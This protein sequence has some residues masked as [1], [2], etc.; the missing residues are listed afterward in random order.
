MATRITARMLINTRDFV[1]SRYGAARFDEM[2]AALG[3]RCRVLYQ[4]KLTASIWVDFEVI[5]DLMQ[6]VERLFGDGS[7][8]L[9]HE[10]G[11]YNSEADLRVTQKLIMRILT[12]KMVLKLAS[13]L[14]TGRVKDGGRMVIINKGP[15]AV[16]CRIE[17]PPSVSDRWWRYLAG[18][19]QRTI[20][21]AGGRQV[22]SRFTGG[23]AEPGQAAE[24][25]VS[26]R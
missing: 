13:F 11:L 10:L 26:W 1:L 17:Q 2:L 19:F 5:D 3:D 20:E 23:G 7:E 4:A 14:W 6:T 24:F 12:I 9:M 8:N 16:G 21:L 22:T 25:D 15:K 18:W